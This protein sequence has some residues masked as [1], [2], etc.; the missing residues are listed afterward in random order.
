[1]GL[2]VRGTNHVMSGLEL[3]ALVPRHPGMERDWRLDQSPMVN[4][5]INHDNVMKPP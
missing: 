2:V 5:L 3:S 4:D 1:M